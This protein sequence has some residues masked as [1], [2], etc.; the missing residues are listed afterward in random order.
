MIHPWSSMKCRKVQDRCSILS[1]INLAV[2]IEVDF[3]SGKKA[4]NWVATLE[5]QC[6]GE[7]II[8]LELRLFSDKALR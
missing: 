5:D 6:G 7:D 8:I 3:S 2:N 4:D 1:K